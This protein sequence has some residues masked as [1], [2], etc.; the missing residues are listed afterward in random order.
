MSTEHLQNDETTEGHKNRHMERHKAR[1]A[2]K[3]GGLENWPFSL[4][5]ASPGVIYSAACR[6]CLAR[7]IRLRK[8]EAARSERPNS[9]QR[10]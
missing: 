10:T 6:E 4:Q 8:W 3:I 9:P 1:L 5:R 7:Y 2:P